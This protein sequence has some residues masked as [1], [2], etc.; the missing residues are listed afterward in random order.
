MGREGFRG[1]PSGFE[2]SVWEKD[3]RKRNNSPGRGGTSRPIVGR[4]GNNIAGA[5]GAGGTGARRTSDNLP[6]VRPSPFH[7]GT[8]DSTVAEISRLRRLA[9]SSLP[10]S[11]DYD[12]D[13]G[14]GV[15]PSSSV[16]TE[17]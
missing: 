4:S 14:D 9:T 7:T 16:E 1:D 12:G 3:R 6:S 10:A 13:D 5:A 2:D 8:R 17:G 15:L 11:E